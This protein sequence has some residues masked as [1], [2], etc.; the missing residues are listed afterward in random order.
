[1]DRQWFNSANRPIVI[2][3]LGSR[4][5]KSERLLFECRGR[6]SICVTCRLPCFREVNTAIVARGRAEDQELQ[7]SIVSHYRTFVRYLFNIPLDSFSFERIDYRGDL[8]HFWT[9]IGLA[10]EAGFGDWTPT[11]PIDSQQTFLRAFL[12]KDWNQEIVLLV[13]ESSELHASSEEVLDSFLRTLREARNNAA[14][15]AIRSVIAAGTFNNLRLNS[16]NP[17]I[18]L[19]NASD[20]VIN[21]YFTVTDTKKLF[22][23][24]EKDYGITIE[25]AVVDDIWTR[26]SYIARIHLPPLTLRYSHPGMI[27]LCGCAIYSNLSSLLC[28]SLTLV[29]ETW[30]RFPVTDLYLEISDY[31]TFRSMRSS[32]MRP[33]AEAALKLLRSHFAGYLEPV[34]LPEGHENLAD[35]LTTEGVLLRPNWK[36]R[37]YHMTS[38]LL[39]GYIRTSVLPARFSRTP[40]IFP[41]FQKTAND[42]A[43]LHVLSV[44]MESLKYFD[45]DTIRLAAFR[46]YKTSAVKVGGISCATV[47]RE[48][49]YD[50]ELMGILSNWLQANYGWS[51]TAQW[52]LCAWSR[53]KYTYIILK[54]DNHHT[55]VLELFATGNRAFIQSHIDKMPE[56]MSL[57]SATE[58]CIVHF[59][60]EDNFHPIWQSD[61]NLDDG[62]K[63]VHF[64]HNPA[65]TRVWMSARFKD[66]MGDTTEIDNVLADI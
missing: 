50:T 44:L 64:S 56:Y 53:H 29:Y 38:P 54:K 63:M 28:H 10:L 12:R 42:T 32:L 11:T 65:F 20:S 27:C 3:L 57:L 4:T 13:D 55:I 16:S 47:P 51:V 6:R 62:I 22:S 49:V 52:H 30:Q 45:K 8:S 2:L 1:M 37:S 14:A 24:F 46:S 39:D 5:T 33:N 40:S 34:E 43:T 59:T 36:Q 66:A 31:P 9:S 60:C 18:S 21:A 7:G 48:S 15:Y 35:F 17:F 23:E 58:A 25:D 26:V 19:F 61:T 41:Q